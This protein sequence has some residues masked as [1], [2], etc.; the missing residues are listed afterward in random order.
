MAVVFKELAGSPV[1]TYEPEGLKAERRLLCAYEDRHAVVAALLGSDQLGGP[2]RAFY[3]GYP[4]VV[5]VRVRVEP[6]ERKPDQR[7]QFDDLTADLNSYSGQFVEVRIQYE[8]FGIDGGHSRL[9]KTRQGTFL[10]Y[11]MDFGGEYLVQPEHTLH[12]QSDATIPV[13]PGAAP[14]LRIPITEH[15]V[16]W[17]RV[18][19]PPWDAMRECIGAVNAGPFL[20]AAAETVLFDGAKA[21]RQ[22]TGLDD[23]LQPQFGWRIT[24]VFREK[25]IKTL[26]GDAC[27][28]LY[29]WNH[30]YRSQP[31]GGSHW[32]KLLD[33]DGNTLYRPMD[34]ASL[35]E[36]AAEM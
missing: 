6:F 29:G 31:A 23:L 13:S 15:H 9:P 22:F 35:F 19:N 26:D 34:F 20:G 21:D 24:Y 17:H 25:T 2:S 11:R 28:T 12:W 14:T 36:F 7:G 32:D 16:T 8:L 10:T 27:P 3:P 4:G 1:E 33:D 18:A 30:S 5:A